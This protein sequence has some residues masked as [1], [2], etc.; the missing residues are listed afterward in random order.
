MKSRWRS[1]L[2]LGK[3]IGFTTVELVV[4]L[5][6]FAILA[7]MAA[8]SFTAMVAKYRISTDHNSFVADLVLARSEA[9]RRGANV[10]VCQSNNGT[11][12]TGTGWGTG[13]VVFVDGGS[14]GQIDGNDTILKVSPAISI[15]T[16]MTPSFTDSFIQYGS[17]GVVSTSG[18]VLTCRTGYAGLQLSIQ[19]VGRI[20]TIKPSGVCP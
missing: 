20:G 16:T 5:S 17:N 8:P 1:N 13:R 2:V 10:S 14:A 11:T 19:K 7:S 12:C 15:G 18:T 6:I 3:V 9:V 4:T